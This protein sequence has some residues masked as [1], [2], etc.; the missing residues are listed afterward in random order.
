MPTIL[1]VVQN[2]IADPLGNAN[3]TVSVDPDNGDPGRG[4]VVDTHGHSAP[5]QS[6][7]GNA[8]DTLIFGAPPF[9]ASQ[10]VETLS[11]WT[12]P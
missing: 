1:S 7:T 10:L 11:A 2:G 6:L 9:R 4:T 3:F 5:W 12:E 8:V